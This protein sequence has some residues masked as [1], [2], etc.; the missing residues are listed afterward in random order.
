M[1]LCLVIGHVAY[2]QSNPSHVRATIAKNTDYL[3]EIESHFP[4]VGIFNQEYSYVNEIAQVS[5]NGNTFQRKAVIEDDFIG[6]ALFAMEWYTFEMPFFT[7]PHL[8]FYEIEVVE[9][10]IDT[11][12]DVVIVDDPNTEVEIYPLLNDYAEFAPLQLI[13]VAHVMYGEA[14]VTDSN[15]IIY[16]APANLEGEDYIVYSVRDTIEEAGVGN[17]VISLSDDN[18]AANDTLR[19]VLSD[20]EKQLVVFPIDGMSFTNATN[21]GDIETLSDYAYRYT[22][23][24]GFNGTDTLYFNADTVQ[25][26]V[27]MEVIPVSEE[28]DYAVDDYYY[29]P[30]NTPIQISPLDNDVKNTFPIIN[31]SDELTYISP[32]VYEFV[33]EQDFEGVKVYPYTIDYGS[34]TATGNIYISVSNYNPQSEMAYNF[35]TLQGKPLVI[36]YEV[37]IGDYEFV[38][39]NMNTGNGLVMAHGE[40]TN[41]TIDNC[42]NVNGEAFIIY[43]PNEVFTGT[44]QFSVDYCTGGVCVTYEVTVE[45]LDIASEDCYCANDCVWAGDANKDGR[46]NVADLLPMGRHMGYAGTSRTAL[47]ED[48]WL[49]EQTTN[50]TYNQVNGRNMKHVD[51][52]GDGIITEADTSAIIANYDGLNNFVPKQ[53]WPIKDFPFYLHTDQTEVEPGDLVTMD[54][55]MGN[56]QYPVTDLYGVAFSVQIGP[57]FADSSS[58]NLTFF[59]DSWLTKDGPSLQM[60]MSTADGYVEAA[61]TRTNGLPASGIG[62]IGQ[63]EFIV[64]DEADGFK[65]DDGDV[66]F[67]VTLQSAG[68]NAGG[69]NYNFPNAGVRLKFNNPG[70]KVLNTIDDKKASDLLIMP[71][72]ASNMITLGVSHSEIIEEVIMTDIAGRSYHM[73]N[74]SNIDVSHLASGVYIVQVKTSENLYTQKLQVIQ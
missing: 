58:M 55:I 30:T 19:F 3:F 69:N 21:D 10:V 39:D 70:D 23:S 54:I 51:S 66:Y 45:V 5:N 12:V 31:I 6:T 56:T 29:T 28:L 52:N 42:E 15:T 59:E 72:P 74:E 62:V 61:V 48:Q 44:D 13:E 57:N 47:F 35:K 41:V 33:P 17:I 25:R 43:Y 49:A 1:V 27:I 60:Q 38:I 32:G 24:L 67:G 20:V 8:T 50:W 14:E 63:L 71:N 40:E 53:N 26:V 65:D 11:E 2:S 34:D 37:P 7:V 36:K 22:P 4:P 64:E 9:S 46:V 18:P 68:G 16:H 73:S